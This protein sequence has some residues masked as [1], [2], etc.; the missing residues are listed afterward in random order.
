MPEELRPM[1]N[2]PAETNSAS[3]EDF[4][5]NAIARMERSQ[6]ARVE[7]K[8]ALAEPPEE[9]LE[10]VQKFKQDV[11]A[12]FSEMTGLVFDADGRCISPGKIR[13]D[14]QIKERW[15]ELCQEFRGSQDP[16]QAE[17]LLREA[18]R[19]FRGAAAVEPDQDKQNRR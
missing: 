1:L 12:R 4:G 18:G 6:E 15:A 2:T 11:I 13:M 9:A 14:E 3:A 10:R 5:K 17:K 8:R 19:I 7:L 16:Q